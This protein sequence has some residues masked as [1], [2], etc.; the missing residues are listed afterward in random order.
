MADALITFKSLILNA[1]MAIG[2]Q[3]VYILPIYVRP[4]KLTGC[5]WYK[6]NFSPCNALLKINDYALSG[7]FDDTTRLALGS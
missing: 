1:F 3:V 5:M 7:N 2:E 4:C 6:A